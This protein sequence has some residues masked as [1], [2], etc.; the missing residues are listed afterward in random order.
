RFTTDSRRTVQVTG[1]AGIPEGATSAVV[2]VTAV[3]P[4]AEGFVTAFPAGTRVPN[5][6]NL[7][8]RAGETR[9]NLAVVSLS[10]SGAIELQSVL[11]YYLNG[12]VDLIVDVF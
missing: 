1:R 11:P 9:P 6:S 3:S 2:N 8:L 4:T 10:A 7:N 12:S 5:A